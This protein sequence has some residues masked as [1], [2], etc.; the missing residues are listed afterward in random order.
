MAISITNSQGSKIYICAGADTTVTTAVNV[1]AAIAAGKQIG[2]LQNIGDIGTSRSVQEYSCMS[3]DAVAKSSGSMSLGNI[4]VSMLYNAADT[5]G[6][7]ELRS[8]YASG[9]TRTI[10]IVLNDIGA[11]YPTY[12]TFEGFISAQSVS[13]QKDNAV[14]M[15]STIEIASVPDEIPAT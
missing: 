13:I 14:M 1:V 15:T 4:A 3:E 7:A 8:I 5:A 10:V 6:Q 9:S 2:C 11:T 12:F